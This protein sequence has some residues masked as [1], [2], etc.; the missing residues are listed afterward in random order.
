[1][2]SDYDFLYGLMR[3]TAESDNTKL[4]TWWN[5]SIEKHSEKFLKYSPENVKFVYENMDKFDILKTLELDKSGN[6][7]REEFNKV[8]FFIIL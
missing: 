4:M 1:M 3:T 2:K 8:L 7:N 5:K 6:V